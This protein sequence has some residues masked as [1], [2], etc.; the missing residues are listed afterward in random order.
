MTHTVLATSP[1]IE[2]MTQLALRLI[3]TWYIDHQGRLGGQY[4]ASADW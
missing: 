4:Q 1:A 3:G 2:V